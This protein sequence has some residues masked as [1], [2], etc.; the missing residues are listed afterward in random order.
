MKFYSFLAYFICYL[1]PSYEFSVFVEL[2]ANKKYRNNL[3]IMIY[4]L[5]C[6]IIFFVT[7]FILI[8]NLI[9]NSIIFYQPNYLE[10]RSI[11]IIN[12]NNAAYSPLFIFLSQ[13]LQ[14]LILEVNIIFINFQF[15]I[16]INYFKLYAL[17][18]VLLNIFFYLI[19]KMI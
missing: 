19:I 6:I 4:I 3:N 16:I 5:I 15:F 18:L 7:I 10:N 13:A 12:I 11:F 8:T 14:K 9:L 17:F 2:I 1:F